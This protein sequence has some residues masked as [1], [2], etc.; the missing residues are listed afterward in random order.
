MA[1]EILCNVASVVALEDKVDQPRM[2]LLKRARGYLNGEWCHIAGKIEPGEAAWQAALRE[3]Q[4]ETGLIPRR[5]YSADYT[6]QFYEHE[7]D[8]VSIVPAFVAYV[9]AES[10]A[11]L[12]D[13]HSESRWVSFAEAGTLVVFGGQRRLYEEIEREFVLRRPSKWHSIPLG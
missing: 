8:V 6:E 4:E 13:E 1:V 11:R 5:F 12:N 7:R 3:L 9:D 10:V 2:L